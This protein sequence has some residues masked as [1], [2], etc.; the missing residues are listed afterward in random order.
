MSAAAIPTAKLDD[1]ALLLALNEPAR[2]RDAVAALF[3]RYA[4]RLRSYFMRQGVSA[5]DADDLVQDSF[6][7]MVRSASSFEARGRAAAWIW[8]LARSVW[9]DAMRHQRRQ[10]IQLSVDEADALAAPEAPLDLKDC[11]QR[12]FGSFALI[13][14]LQAQVLYWAA[15]D[16]LTAPEISELI[17]RSPGAT[18][19]FLS[20]IRKRL[21]NVLSICQEYLS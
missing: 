15:V 13:E 18:R 20:Q 19:E 3:E 10:G 12:A 21:R 9:L 2:R 14:P 6:V 5:S 16:Q 4:S 17:D 8:Q 7:K 1:D 11:V